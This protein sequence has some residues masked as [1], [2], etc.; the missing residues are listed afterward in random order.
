MDNLQ[1]SR[2]KH[3]FIFEEYNERHRWSRMKVGD[4]VTLNNQNWT[5]T[6]FLVIEKSWVRN[7]WIIWS[8]ETGTLQ[9]NEKRLEVVSESR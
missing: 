5:T 3:S 1:L 4:L 7:E 9:W 2:Q 6:P 8:A